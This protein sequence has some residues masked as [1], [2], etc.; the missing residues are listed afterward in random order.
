MK[1]SMEHWNGCQVC[2]IDVETTGLNPLI[3]EIWQLAIVPLDSNFDQRKDVMPFY[4]H[5]IPENMNSVDFK[6]HIRSR[7]RFHEY[8]RRGL[9]KEKAVDLLETWI[10]KLELPYNKSGYNRAKIIPLGQNYQFDL[11]FMR[12]WLRDRYDEWFRPDYRDTMIAASYLN[13]VYGMKNDNVPF[14]KVN[15]QYLCSQTNTI[16]NSAHD[17]LQDCVATA[18]VYKWMTRRN[19][20]IG[21]R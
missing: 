13:D 4:V 10:E 14:P 19:M 5:M 21:S 18:K 1:N 17:A 12:R 16:N 2:V 15:L 7:D 6:N 9:D 8:T 20:I 3:H 11:G